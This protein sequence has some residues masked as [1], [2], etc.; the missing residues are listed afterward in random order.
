MGFARDCSGSFRSNDFPL[1]LRP[2]GLRPQGSMPNRPLLLLYH[3]GM[4]LTPL[5]VLFDCALSPPFP[6]GLVEHT[7]SSEVLPL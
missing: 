5:L 3:V 7:T 2:S 6:V 4:Y 1:D